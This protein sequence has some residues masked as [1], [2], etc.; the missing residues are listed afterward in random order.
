MS[1]TRIR[2][3][4]ARIAYALRHPLRTRRHVRAISAPFD[5]APAAAE[6]LEHA[7]DRAAWLEQDLDTAIDELVEE[8]TR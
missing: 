7:T 4:P 5:P 2:W 3:T 6:L 8:L 1:A